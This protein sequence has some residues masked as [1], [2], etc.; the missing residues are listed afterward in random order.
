MCELADF[1]VQLCVGD[2]AVVAPFVARDQGDAVVPVSQQ[3]L[4]KVQAY[5]RKPLGAGHL[6]AVDEYGVE[7]AGGADAAEF[8]DEFPELRRLADR[9]IVQ[10]R[11]TADVLVAG[12]FAHEADEAVHVRAFDALGAGFPDRFVHVRSLV[13]ALVHVRISLTPVPA[14]EST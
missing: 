7:I 9:K 12:L 4:R 13:A 2:F 5:V 14:P 6:V 1:L 8:P 11:V 10:R 3:V